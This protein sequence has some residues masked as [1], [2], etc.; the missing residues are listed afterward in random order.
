MTYDKRKY[1][2]YICNKILKNKTKTKCKKC[3]T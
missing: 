2:C 1:S 3:D